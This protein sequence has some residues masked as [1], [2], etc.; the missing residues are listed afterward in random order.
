M[1]IVKWTLE[2]N[3]QLIQRC[4]G[5]QIL[6]QY[7]G[8]S[9]RL[10]KPN[11]KMNKLMWFLMVRKKMSLTSCKMTCNGPVSR[12]III[13][14]NKRRIS[15]LAWN[16]KNLNKIINECLIN[17]CKK[18]YRINNLIKK[19]TKNSTKLFVLK[20]KSKMNEKENCLLKR[21]KEKLKWKW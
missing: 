14:C 6:I 20:S 2:A 21:G 17:K 9:I 12:N 7:W 18:N 11:E 10:P 5:P 1:I 15:L 8:I 19:M 16:K 3:D 13:I 4:Q